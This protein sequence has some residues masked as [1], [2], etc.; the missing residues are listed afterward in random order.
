MLVG[1]CL[2]LKCWYIGNSKSHCDC[3]MMREFE[4]GQAWCYLFCFD[5]NF[6]FVCV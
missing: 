3:Q 5:L 4:P 2:D 6:S 1:D